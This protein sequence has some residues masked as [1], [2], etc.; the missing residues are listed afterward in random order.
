VPTPEIARQLGVAYVIEGS[1]VRIGEKVKISARLIKA[2]D[3]FQ[4]WQDSFQRDAK[5]VFAVEEEIAG[6][7]AKKLSLK[8]GVS[9]AAATASVNPEAF[10]LYVR[11]RGA[12]N[13]RTAEGFDQAEQL[14]QRVLV[15]EPKFARA[16]AALADVWAQRLWRS[17][18]AN[19]ADAKSGGH[20][21]ARIKAKITDAIRFDRDSAEAHASLGDLLSHDG[22]NAEAESA[23]RRAV[24]L[25]PNL[26]VAHQWLGWVL[27]NSGNIDE[28][29]KHLQRATELDPLAPIVWSFYG[30][31]L[32]CAGRYAESLFAADRALALKPDEGQAVWGKVINLAAL[33]RSAEAVE[34]VRSLPSDRGLV[35]AS[36][37]FAFARAGLRADAETL[38]GQR[39]SSRYWA[40]GLIALGQTDE[41]MALLSSQWFHLYFAA[42]FLWDPIYDS[43]RNDPRWAKFIA[44]LGLSEAHARA[45]AWRKAHPP[46][47]PVA[48]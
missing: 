8:L 7:I 28:A 41:A 46:E 18:A 29:L 38:L 39:G 17:P 4:E 48:K 33:G 12:W 5:D 10:E 22:K 25:N 32:R 26:A 9:S 21:R 44:D 14:L 6:L 43:L 1:V 11:A 2:A 34:L 23:L 3:G 36:Q 37:L 19:Q 47:K 20:E 30:S 31:G 13:S 16:H 15:L 40:A 35:G 45:Q 24:T 42:D 27:L